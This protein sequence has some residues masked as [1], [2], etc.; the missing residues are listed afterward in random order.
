M[1]LTN[2][3]TMAVGK[4]KLKAS[5]NSPHILFGVGVVGIVTSHILVARATL[6][7]EPVL[8]EIKDD[9]DRAKRKPHIA[10]EHDIS[11]NES[12]HGREMLH[13]YTT[14]ALKLGKLYGPTLVIG[15]ASLY[16]LTRSH[17]TLTRR[18]AALAAGYAAI[19][20]EFKEYR[21]RVREEIGD[22]KEQDIYLGVKDMEIDED[23]KK[24][25]IKGIDRLPSP[26]ARFFDQFSS[27]WEKDP[28]R[29]RYF[30]QCQQNYWNQRLHAYGHVFLNEVYDSLGLERSRE[31]AVVGWL[32][33]GSGAGYIDFG[34]YEETNNAR[35]INNLE[36]SALLDF[37]VD[38]PIH[39]K[40]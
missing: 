20:Q 18:N 1:N 40:I 39:N 22:D 29:N 32:L 9:V 14:A 30:L 26:Y 37:N 8:D 19:T 36:W 35:F 23:G 3:A 7:L 12:E 4:M 13:V 38:G 11:Y 10:S 28:E 27:Q 33:D 34:L 31:G 15:S 21:D 24:K 5:R 2:K 25:K 17:M 6:K 16:A